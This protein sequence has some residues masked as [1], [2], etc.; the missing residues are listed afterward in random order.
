MVPLSHSWF[1]KAFGEEK[2]RKACETS[3]KILTHNILESMNIKIKE[4][5]DIKEISKTS[6]I[7][8]MAII[9][10]IRENGWDN[11]EVREFCDQTFSLYRALDIPD[12]HAS[13]LKYYVKLSCFGILGARTVDVQMWLKEKPWPEIEKSH[14]NWAEQVFSLTIDSFLRTVR[15]NGWKDRRASGWPDH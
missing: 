6:E 13:A 4:K 3:N 12:A 7:M 1:I 11:E 9:D 14:K 10:R 5:V 2:L 8:E 15:K